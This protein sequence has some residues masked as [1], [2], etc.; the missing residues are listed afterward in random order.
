MSSR[1]LSGTL[2]AV[3]AFMTAAIAAAP[4]ASACGLP[5]SQHCYGIVNSGSVSGIV[6]VNVSVSP[7][8]LSSPTVN[9]ANDEMWLVTSTSSYWVEVGYKYQN[10]VNDGGVTQNGLFAFW[11]DSRPVG[12]YH[13]H[14][15]QNNP[16]F[17][18]TNLQ[19]TKISTDTWAI[20]FGGFS[21]TSTGNSM[22]PN[23]G[24]WG[25]EATSAS[26]HSYSFARTVEYKTGTTWHNGVPSPAISINAPQ[27][28]AWIS[29]T[30]SYNAGI[31]C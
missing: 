14:V 26:A 10:G 13:T 23:H 18:F 6:G 30:T 5:N 7:S 28:F 4:S 24:S 9:F 19:I 25:S 2:V 1:R 12:G 16:S 31:A 20:H 3:L 15:L 11:S 29:P 21:G 27:Q 8:C 22:V 17:A